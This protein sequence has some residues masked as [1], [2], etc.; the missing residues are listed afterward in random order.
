MLLIFTRMN[1]PLA[2]GFIDLEDLCISLEKSE[3]QLMPREK[4]VPIKQIAIYG[5]ARVLARA[6]KNLQHQAR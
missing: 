4:V 3:Q 2:I 6:V 5:P 1:P